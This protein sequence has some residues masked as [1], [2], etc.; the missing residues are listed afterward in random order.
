MKVLDR[1]RVYCLKQSSWKH[2]NSQTG[3][4]HMHWQ[5]KHLEKCLKVSATSP[6]LDQISTCMHMQTRSL[7]AINL[8][9]CTGDSG[10][11][12]HGKRRTSCSWH[13]EGRGGSQSSRQATGSGW[14]QID[15]P[16]CW[17]YLQQWV[18]HKHTHTHSDI[19]KL[20][21]T[22]WYY[23]NLALMWVIH[24]VFS[25][26]KVSSLPDQ[27]CRRGYLSLCYN[28]RWIWDAV[29]SQPLGWETEI[30]MNYVTCTSICSHFVFILPLLCVS[31]SLSS[32][33]PPTF[34]L[35]RSL[36]PDLSATGLAEALSPIPSHQPVIGRPRPRQDPFWWPEWWEKLSPC[37]GLRTEQAGQRPVHQRAGQ[38]DWR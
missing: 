4:C 34:S 15:L 9:R 27:Q 10:V 22:E 1:M 37:Q 18:A 38:E 8:C 2:E 17:E 19:C 35:L 6:Y 26:W 16:V 23:C 12:E 24:I 20:K 31:N 32:V 21:N 7:K 28:S 14:H 33:S 29:W 30:L 13:L 3:G 5:R 25:S 11:Q 36:L